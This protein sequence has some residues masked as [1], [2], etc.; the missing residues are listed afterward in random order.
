[1]S[2]YAKPLPQIDEANRP[3]WDALRA[4][5][6]DVLTCG[7]CGE[8]RIYTFRKCPKCGS[9]TAHWTTLP[10][11]GEIWSLGTFHQVYFEGFRAEVPSTVAIVQLDGGPRVYSNIVETEARA[12]Q[13]GARVAPVFDAV[14]DEVTLL[15][16]RV[17][18]APDKQGD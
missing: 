1:M 7:D 13:I 8:M 16:F 5:R 17:T 4:G 18:A 11:T 10:G 3:Y 15:K 6:V 9:E 12:V 2:A 14:T